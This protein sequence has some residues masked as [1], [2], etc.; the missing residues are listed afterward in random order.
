MG[1]SAPHQ[2]GVGSA[3]QPGPAFVATVGSHRLYLG[4]QDKITYG[5]TTL[6]AQIPGLAGYALALIG[7]L[8]FVLVAIFCV[9]RAP[10][11]WPG[12]RSR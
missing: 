5:E 12:L 2:P 3:V 4:M 1:H 8:G 10:D 6:I 9:I 11:V 7:A